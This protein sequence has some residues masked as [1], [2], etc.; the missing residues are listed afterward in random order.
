MSSTTLP[1]DSTV[2]FDGEAYRSRPKQLARW[3]LE[4]RNRLRRKYRE[5]KVE[6]K[7]L[8][9]ALPET[10]EHRLWRRVPI[11]KISVGIRRE[12]DSES[13]DWAGNGVDIN[14][15][16]M[17]LVLPLKLPAGTRVFLNFRLGDADFSRVPAEILRQENVGIGA[18]RFVDWSDSDQLELVSFLQKTA[19][20][21]AERQN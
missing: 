13:P 11:A 1:V 3:L 14:N 18:V 5:V 20:L 10:P 8:N 16:G 9:A 15:G 19:G 6:S 2:V 7:R 17:A 12:Q 21:S 4:S